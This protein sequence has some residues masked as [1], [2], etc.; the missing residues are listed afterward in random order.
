[1]KQREIG[2]GRLWFWLKR[3]SLLSSRVE[4]FVIV[5]L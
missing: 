5:E 1:M 3:L 4:A 2:R